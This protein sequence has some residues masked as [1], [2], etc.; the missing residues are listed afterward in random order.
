MYVKIHSCTTDGGSRS[1]GK[2]TEVST[3]SCECETGSCLDRYDEPQPCLR[4][5]GVR[6]YGAPRNL[7]GKAVER[8]FV[9]ELTE[10]DLRKILEHAANAGMLPVPELQ[11]AY[12]ALTVCMEKL[13]LVIPPKG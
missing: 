6:E 3:D 10:S 11:D 13:N 12:R 8:S 9:V 4:I 1:H 7:Y 5:S 2:N